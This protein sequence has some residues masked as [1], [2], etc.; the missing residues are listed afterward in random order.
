MAVFYHEHV[1]LTTALAIILALGGIALLYQ[2]GTNVRITGTG[3]ALVLL[4]SLLYALYIVG[5]NQWKTDYSPLKFTFWIVF[6]GLLAVLVY[7]YASGDRLQMLHGAGEWTNALQLALMPTVLSLF[8]MTISI[9]NI[10]ST[11]SAIMGAFEPLTAVAIGV[12][13][14]GETFTLRLAI[15]IVLILTGVTLVIARK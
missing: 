4:S 5:V 7:T 6:F 15:G 2:G 1:T 12:L 3:I 9:K 8:F 11:P 14:F 13:V 10:G